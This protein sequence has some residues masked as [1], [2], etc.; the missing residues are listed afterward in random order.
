MQAA[1]KRASSCGGHVIKNFGIHQHAW[2]Q[3]DRLRPRR[4]TVQLLGGQL[5]SGKVCGC[6]RARLDDA[7]GFLQSVLLFCGCI[8]TSPRSREKTAQYRVIV[9]E[10]L[11]DAG[12][13]F[14]RWLT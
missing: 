3:A 5:I 11:G 13:P 9:C 8:I 6:S 4:P 10:G 7:G 14:A 2:R 12:R 1:R